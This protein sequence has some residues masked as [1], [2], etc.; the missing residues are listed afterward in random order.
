M[1]LA[2][3]NNL[4]FYLTLMSEIRQAIKKEKL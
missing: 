2:T 4:S 1:R 3:L